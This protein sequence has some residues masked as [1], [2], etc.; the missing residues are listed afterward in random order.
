MPEKEYDIIIVGAGPA[1]LAAGLYGARSMRK[2]LILDKYI[3]LK[4]LGDLK[5]Y[6]YFFELLILPCSRLCENYYQQGQNQGWYDKNLLMGIRLRHNRC[7]LIRHY[8]NAK[9]QSSM[10]NAVYSMLLPITMS[11][12]AISVRPSVL[13]A[14]STL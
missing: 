1:G 8:A 11:S 2:T 12:G 14:I 5:S 9:T 13:I 10:T 6:Y 4:K 7:P 3:L